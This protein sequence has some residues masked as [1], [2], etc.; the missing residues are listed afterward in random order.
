MFIV[1]WYFVTIFL[2][3]HREQ[4]LQEKNFLFHFINRP[5]RMLGKS[6]DSVVSAVKASNIQFFHTLPVVRSP[7][8]HRSSNSSR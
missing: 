5:C 6:N 1:S 8:I 3:F 4:L 2:H 7:P